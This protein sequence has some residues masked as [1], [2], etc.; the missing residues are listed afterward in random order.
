MQAHPPSATTT[1]VTHL[2]VVSKII[3]NIIKYNK[4]DMKYVHSVRGAHS[5]CGGDDTVM[6]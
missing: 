4:M 3:E 6:C 5:Q 1:V 2:L